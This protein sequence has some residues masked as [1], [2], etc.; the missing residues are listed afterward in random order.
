MVVAAMARSLDSQV[1]F[2]PDHRG[3]R[4]VLAFGA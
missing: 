4:A 2:D 3:V 1:T